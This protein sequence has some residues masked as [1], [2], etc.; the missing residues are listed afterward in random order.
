MPNIRTLALDAQDELYK[1]RIG[2][3]LLD[4]A[5]D[6]LEDTPDSRDEKVVLL[7]DCYLSRAELYLDE[8]KA[9]LVQIYQQAVAQQETQQRLLLWRILFS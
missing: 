1:L 9:D 2:G 4:I 6:L 7:L 3:I 5:V 8:L